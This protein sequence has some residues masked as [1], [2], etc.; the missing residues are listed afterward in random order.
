MNPLFLVASQRIP[1]KKPR[2]QGAMEFPGF[3]LFKFSLPFD[4]DAFCTFPSETSAVFTLQQATVPRRME[5][6]LHG[7]NHNSWIVW[8][9]GLYQ[10]SFTGW[11]FNFAGSLTRPW[12]REMQ[13]SG[14]NHRAFVQSKWFR[15]WQGVKVPN[16]FIHS[17]FSFLVF[18]KTVTFAPLIYKTVAKLTV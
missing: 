1:S 15:V 8:S 17:F 10:D 12:E 13:V 4:Q 7:T 2:A 16:K 3:S 14:T 11:R 5:N 9:V 6:A 18:L